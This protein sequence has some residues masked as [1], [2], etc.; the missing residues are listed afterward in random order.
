MKVGDV[1]ITHSGFKKEKWD[2]KE[3]IVVRMWSKK[4]RVRFNDGPETGVEKDYPLIHLKL[5][6]SAPKS[7]AT[8]PPAGQKRAAE[9]AASVEPK[10]K[11]LKNGGYSPGDSADAIF[12]PAEKV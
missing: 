8:V 3:A 12:G 6:Q 5:H 11:A 10:T 4:A 2:K 7:F 1:V 9:G